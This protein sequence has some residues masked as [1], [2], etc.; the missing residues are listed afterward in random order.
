M[1]RATNLARAERRFEKGV[2]DAMRAFR[3]SH[4]PPAS[5]PGAKAASRCGRAAASSP[6]GVV[7][8]TGAAPFPHQRLG[9]GIAGAL[10]SLSL[11]FGPGPGA[12]QASLFDFSEIGR[13]PIEP[14][15]LYGDVMK[16]FFIENLDDTGKV[17]E[18]RE[19][20][21]PLTQEGC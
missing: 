21:V 10:L 1:A 8:S 16:K 5:T 2:L 14:F 6:R 15:T 17:R 19:T 3:P 20:L 11:V 7:V 9:R 18:G 4:S 13:D 12:A